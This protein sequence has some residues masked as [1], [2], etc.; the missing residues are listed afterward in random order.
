SLAAGHARHECMSIAWQQFVIISLLTAPLL[1]R[2]CLSLR[3]SQR[4]TN[5]RVRIR[6]VESRCTCTHTIAL[7]LTFCPSQSPS[8]PRPSRSDTL[9]IPSNERPASRSVRHA[10]QHSMRQYWRRAAAQNRN[11]V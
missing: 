10:W 6:A 5:L 2:T 8:R 7:P 1:A 11:H 9:H 3:D 4:H